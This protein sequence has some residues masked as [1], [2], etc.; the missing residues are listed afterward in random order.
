MSRLNNGDTLTRIDCILKEEM[1]DIKKR[2]LEEGRDDIKLSDR[3][4]SALIVKHNAFPRIKEDAIK[5]EIK[6]R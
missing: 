3:I 2:R 6:Q 4:I 5:Y 1:R